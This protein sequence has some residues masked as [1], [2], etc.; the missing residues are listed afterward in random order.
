MS[1]NLKVPIP[2]QFYPRKCRFS[3]L[4]FAKRIHFKK[5]LEKV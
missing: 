1:P 4:N 3:A 5:S 2:N